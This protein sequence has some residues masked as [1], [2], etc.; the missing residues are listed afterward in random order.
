MDDDHLSWRARGV[1]ASP[2]FERDLGK[3]R[4]DAQRDRRTSRRFAEMSLEALREHVERQR[5]LDRD[6]RP[7]RWSEKRLRRDTFDPAPN[8]PAAAAVRYL[9]RCD[10]LAGYYLGAT[11]AAPVMHQAACATLPVVI[12]PMNVIPQPAPYGAMASSAAAALSGADWYTPEARR[13]ALHRATPK[14]RSG[15]FY[16]AQVT[17]SRPNAG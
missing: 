16:M 6:Q 15:F 8:E 3:L 5:D 2:R 14:D 7:H 4:A 10:V 9:K 1:N 17:G 12:E 11:A 13:V